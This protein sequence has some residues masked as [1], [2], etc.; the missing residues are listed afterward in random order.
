MQRFFT[1]AFLVAAVLSPLGSLAS[2][3]RN[4]T[5]WVTLGDSDQLVEVDPYTF[6]V[7][8]RIKV[9]QRPHGL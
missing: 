2:Q 6:S 7:I 4:A 9:D 1:W 3:A 5:L 8:R